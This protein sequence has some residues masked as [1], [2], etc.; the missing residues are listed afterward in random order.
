MAA[1]GGENSEDGKRRVDL[2]LADDVVSPARA[3]KAAGISDRASRV[4]WPQAQP[5]QRLARATCPLS[6]SVTS[7]A[8]FAISFPKPWL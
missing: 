2:L 6:A 7:Q 1:I 8:T 3:A 5:W 4:C